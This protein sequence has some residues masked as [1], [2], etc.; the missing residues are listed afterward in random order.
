ML[1]WV[2]FSTLG[3]LFSL[4]VTWW[5]HSQH[6]LEIKVLPSEAPPAEAA[7][8]IS[9]IVPARNEQRNIGACVNS[10]LKQTYP[11]YELIVVDDRSTDAT[12][13]ILAEIA[14]RDARLRVIHGSPLPHG[15]AGKPHALF[16]GA[17]A[18]LRND[19]WET[20]LCFV[21]ADTFASPDL[22]ASAL[23]TA[24]ATGG[25]LFTMLTRQRLVSFWEKVILPIVFTA[26]S[27]GFSPRKVNDPARPDAV[28]NG[29]F[30]LFRRAAYE[31][32][33]G[34]RGVAGS[35]VEDRDLA[36]RIKAAG[37]R[38]V[39]ADGQA[40]AETRMYTTFQEIWEGWTKNIYLGLSDQRGLAFLGIFGVLLSLLG[41]L[42][43]LAWIALAAAW[44]ARGGGL[45][46]LVVL[47]QAMLAFSVLL[48]VRAQ[49]A[50]AF[51]ISP[52]YGLT[53]PLG[54]LV[55][56]AMMAASAYRVLSRKGVTW[57]GRRYHGKPL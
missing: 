7:P 54:A 42:G 12:P 15:W 22:L 40:V 30:L 29:Q 18:A 48:I 37:L 50:R 47:C 25:D 46:A 28:A 1:F 8:W 33:D 5:V 16:Q 34:H 51:R 49:V 21:D 2:A 6:K 41:A 23:V 39:V 24:Q 43:F 57:K 44:L 14:Q 55:F 45:P 27:V 31:R 19:E 13:Q 35:I 32:I 9:V 38:L 20:W 53:L 52:I 3:L 56:A 26:L 10:L 36:R 11:N 4:A 17:Q